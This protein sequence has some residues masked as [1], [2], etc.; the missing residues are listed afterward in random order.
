MKQPGLASVAVLP[1]PFMMAE[2]LSL[3][4][5]AAKLSVLPGLS[6][7][8]GRT[9]PEELKPAA[10]GYCQNVPPDVLV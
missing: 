9:A 5:K 8:D 1:F 2:V 6:L 10:L 4:L 7:N 3:T